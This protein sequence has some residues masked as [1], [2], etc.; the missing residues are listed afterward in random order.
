MYVKN[1][2]M[3]TDG[4][5]NMATSKSLW[6]PSCVHYNRFFVCFKMANLK[7]TCIHYIT[8]C[9][10]PDNQLV[11]HYI[12]RYHSLKQPKHTWGHLQCLFS[13]KVLQHITFQFLFYNYNKDKLHYR[14]N[15]RTKLFY[16]DFGTSF[17]IAFIPLS[18]FVDE[19]Y[20]KQFVINI[21]LST[22]GI[23]SGLE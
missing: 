1:I 15:Y 11:F 16:L 22:E 9:Q 21:N 6:W 4:I 23:D 20:Y 19:I 14:L 3:Q 13:S 5:G 12:T 17:L 2:Q 18:Y 8:C 10:S 7:S